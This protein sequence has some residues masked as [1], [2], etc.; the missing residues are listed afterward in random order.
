MLLAQALGE[1]GSGLPAVVSSIQ[2]AAI[3]LEERI[4]SIDSTTWLIVGLAAV[5]L[6][7]FKKRR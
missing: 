7:F 2:G 4:S 6:F 3:S 5:V 1:Y